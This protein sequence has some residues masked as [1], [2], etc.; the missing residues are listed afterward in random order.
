MSPE[1]QRTQYTSVKRY[2]MF[3]EIG[4]KAGVDYDYCFGKTI[5]TGSYIYKGFDLIVNTSTHEGLPTP[6]LECSA[7][8]VPFISTKVGIVPQ[9]SSIKTFDTVDEAVEIIKELNSDP[10]ILKKYVEDVYDDVAM[11]NLWQDH[12]S[13]YYNPAFDRVANDVQ[14]P[15]LVV[16]RYNED[17]SWLNEL[18]LSYTIYNKGEDNLELDCI[19]RENVGRETETFLHHIIENYDTME[20]SLCFAQG[21]PFDHLEKEPM[22]HLIKNFNQGFLPLGR[23]ERSLGD[24]R[25]WHEGLPVAET[26]EKLGVKRDDDSYFFAPGAQFVVSCEV[27]KKKPLSFWKNAYD[28][29]MSD[30]STSPWAFERLWFSMLTDN[31]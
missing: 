4:E 27:I 14:Y 16:S 3:S 28:V 21:N 20:G 17:V 22:F 30:L 6:L 25:V 24:G 2:D 1:N 31:V 29:M 13:N 11:N 26:A 19:K 18:G 7:A 8:K 5:H 15:H 12:V 10:K 9:Y 23:P